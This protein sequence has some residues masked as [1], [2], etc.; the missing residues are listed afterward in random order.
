MRGIF[1]IIFLVLTLTACTS[2][3]DI[4]LELD[5]RESESEGVPETEGESM[6]ESVLETESEREAAT[7]SIPGAEEGF[8]A[9]AAQE[10]VPSDIYVHICGAVENPGVYILTA[11]SRVYEG[12]AAAGGFREDACEDFVNQAGILQDGQRLVIPTV[13]E[14]E[15]AKEDGSYQ[16][17]WQEE[18][19]SAGAQTPE[20]ADTADKTSG[21]AG[22]FVNIN[23]ATES[24][25]SAIPGIGA[26]KAAAIIQNRQENRRFAS[27]EDIMKVSG[28]KEGTFEKIKDKITVN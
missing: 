5:G 24:E 20:T 7:E 10:T 18:A 8:K 21:S 28:I 11:G 23:T 3:D 25:L 1:F 26:G 14:T 22:G 6:A 12:V 15:A 13:E 9:E 17:L 2:R 16:A 19:Q 4:V 27:I